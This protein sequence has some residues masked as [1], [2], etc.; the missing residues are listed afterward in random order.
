MAQK[1]MNLIRKHQFFKGKIPLL[2]PPREI[3]RLLKRHVSVVIALD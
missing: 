3:H 2:E 1:A